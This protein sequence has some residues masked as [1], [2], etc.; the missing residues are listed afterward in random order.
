MS[1]ITDCN[2]DDNDNCYKSLLHPTLTC[3]YTV[4]KDESLTRLTEAK[5]NLDGISVHKSNDNFLN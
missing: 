1:T 2:N 4:P 5:I 3:F